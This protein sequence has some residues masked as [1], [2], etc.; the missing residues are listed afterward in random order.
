MDNSDVP[1]AEEHTNMKTFVIFYINGNTEA[2]VAGVV[3]TKNMDATEETAVDWWWHSQ[4]K[5][6]AHMSCY[7]AEKT[8]LIQV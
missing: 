6:P 4:E 1:Y 2:V 8:T 3:T 7:Y 5:E